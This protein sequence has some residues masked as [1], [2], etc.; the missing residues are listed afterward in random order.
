MND[1]ERFQSKYI[2]DPVTGCWLWTACVNK[3]GYG[4]FRYKG[5]T[6]RAH[7]FS[8]ESYVGPIL[9]DKELD[10]KCHDDNCKDGKFCWHRR[11]VNWQHIEPTEHGINARRTGKAKRT[12]CPQGHPYSGDNLKVEIYTSKRRGQIIARRCLACHRPRINAWHRRN[13]KRRKGYKNDIRI[14]S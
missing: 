11:C 14:S 7:R 13:D 2:V 5:K 9:D 1:L 4:H 3:D 6:L 8:Y 10:H 12:H